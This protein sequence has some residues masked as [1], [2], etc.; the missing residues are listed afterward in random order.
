[1]LLMEA[2]QKHTNQREQ[3]WRL[4]RRWVVLHFYFLDPIFSIMKRTI[5][6]GVCSVHNVLPRPFISVQFH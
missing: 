5:I 3:S 1:M 6:K 2:L 4:L